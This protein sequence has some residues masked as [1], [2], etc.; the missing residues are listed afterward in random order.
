MLI[1]CA[2]HLFSV[3]GMKKNMTHILMLL[4]ALLCFQSL[5]AEEGVILQLKDGSEVGFAFSTHPK[6]TLG[7][8]LML[9]L[10]DG[11]SVSYDYSEVKR[12]SFGEVKV[13]DIQEALSAPACAVS[14]KLEAEQVLVS[15]L[16]IGETVCVYNIAGQQ[17]TAVRQT[18]EGTV[19]SVPL[20]QSGILIVRTTTGVS[21]KVLKK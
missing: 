15:G 10:P 20:T 19:L 12:F 6:V 2:R 14:F 3:E 1:G 17:L 18:A 13:T 5:H 11:T 8:E 4:V 21:Y 7:C 16:P 9:S